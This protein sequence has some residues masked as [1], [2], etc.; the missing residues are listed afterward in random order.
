MHEE[1]AGPGSLET[2]RWPGSGSGSPLTASMSAS[3][4]DLSSTR[5][6]G[7]ADHWLLIRC[8]FLSSGAHI[9]ESLS[10]L[11]PHSGKFQ[12]AP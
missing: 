2:A 7:L 3:C 6:A 9:S 1:P 5:A 11:L 4:F 12:R 8:P 10:T